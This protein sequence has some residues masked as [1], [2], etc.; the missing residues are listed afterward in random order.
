MLLLN[1]Q[2]GNIYSL[3]SELF[4]AVAFFL[5]LYEGYCWKKR[6]GEILAAEG[7]SMKN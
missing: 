3:Y 2:E 4:L 1:V 5:D 6:T 7:C